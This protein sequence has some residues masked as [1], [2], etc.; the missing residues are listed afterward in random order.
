VFFFVSC[1]ESSEHTAELAAK[2]KWNC[3]LSV[4]LNFSKF[5]KAGCYNWGSHWQCR[6]KLVFNEIFSVE[7]I[8]VQ[9]EKIGLVPYDKA[10][11]Y[12][13]HVMSLDQD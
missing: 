5:G 6:L 13:R 7:P 3:G 9:A 1:G 2:K 8:P 11:I 12:N 10:F 4:N